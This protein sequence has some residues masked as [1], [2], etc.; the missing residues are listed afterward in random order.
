[1]HGNLVKS[2]LWAIDLRKLFF[3]CVEGCPQGGDCK[4]DGMHPTSRTS[5]V[6][7]E[8]HK[9]IQSPEGPPVATRR[10]QTA[11]IGVPVLRIPKSGRRTR[12]RRAGGRG[13][14]DGP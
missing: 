2:L 1:M 13:A 7:Y 3:E 11:H 14:S 12:S 9:K 10:E 6:Q 4:T 5:F 8:F